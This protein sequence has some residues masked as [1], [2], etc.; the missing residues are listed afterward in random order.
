MS[1]GGCSLAAQTDRVNEWASG[2]TR[3]AGRSETMAP[4]ARVG[5]A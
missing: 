5:F 1:G 2:M 3:S 4:A